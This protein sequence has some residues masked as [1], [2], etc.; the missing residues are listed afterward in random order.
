MREPWWSVVNGRANSKVA[1]KRDLLPDQH[2]LGFD[3]GWVI[4]S[5][6]DLMKS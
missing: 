2:T 3:L 4:E 1:P 6:Q 5:L